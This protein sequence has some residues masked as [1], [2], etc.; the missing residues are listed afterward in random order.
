MSKIKVTCDKTADLSEELLAKYDIATIPLYINMDGKSYKDGE[1][2]LPEDIFK[3]VSQTGI[4]PKT[5]AAS[6]KDYMDLFSTYKDDY[7]SIIHISLGQSFS[8]SYQ[9]ANLASEEF[10]NVYVINSNNLSTGSGHVVLETVKLVEEGYSAEEIL[11]N[12]DQFKEKVEASFVIDTLDYLRMGGRCSSLQAFGAS[13]LNIKPSIEVI[14]GKMEVGKKYRGKIDK[15]IEKYVAERLKNRTDIV[16][17]QIFI[18]HSGCSDEIIESTKQLIKSYQNFEQI[19]VTIASCTISC[20][21]GPN[22]LG[23][24]FKTK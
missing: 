19:T 1:E 8:S 5:A 15:A 6:I 22:T 13:L 9:N 10:S 11:K 18:T 3:Y 21:C 7:E 20:H 2:I 16:T 12:I 14:E 17:D 4:L 24:L 23:I